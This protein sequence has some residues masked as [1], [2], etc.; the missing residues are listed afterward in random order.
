MLSGKSVYIN[1]IRYGVHISYIIE[2]EIFTILE[3]NIDVILL[4]VFTELEL[5]S[6]IS[7]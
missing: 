5:F 3:I 4:L 7:S 1:I 2:Q 6:R